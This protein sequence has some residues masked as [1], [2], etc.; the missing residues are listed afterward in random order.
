MGKWIAGIAGAVI[1]GAVLWLL[2]NVL[3]TRW[4]SHPPPPPEDNVRVECSAIPATLS[5]GGVAQITV[6]VTRGSEPV[7]GAAVKF[8]IGGGLFDS[9]TTTTSGHTYSGGV[10]RTTWTAPS[11]SAAAYVFPADVDL[12]GVRTAKGEL[13]GHY[14]TNCEILVSR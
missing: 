7:E 14:R 8:G 12:Q 5:P 2:T 1:A 3:F 9:G 13:Q 10:F 6:K 11:P 4:F